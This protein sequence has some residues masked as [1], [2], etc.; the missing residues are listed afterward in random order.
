MNKDIFPLTYN[1]WLKIKC[2]EDSDKERW[3]Y[4]EYEASFLSACPEEF[5]TY[6]YENRHSYLEMSTQYPLSHLP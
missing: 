5:R 3:L 6:Y 4:G 1:Q 2:E